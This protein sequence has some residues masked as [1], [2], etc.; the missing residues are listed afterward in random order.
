MIHFNLGLAD[1][2][3]GGIDRVRKQVAAFLNARGVA[4]VIQLNPF[5]FEKG[6]EV[7]EELV[8]LDGFHSL[9]VKL[10]QAYRPAP[11]LQLYNH[12]QFIIE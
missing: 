11:P 10:S 12:S 2:L 1:G 6:A 4:A 7:S 9:L 3:S 5:R 8:F